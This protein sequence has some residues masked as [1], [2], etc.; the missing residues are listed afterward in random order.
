MYFVK[1]VVFKRKKKKQHQQNKTKQTPVSTNHLSFL[2]F[3]KINMLSLLLLLLISLLSVI[4]ALH[5]ACNTNISN[6]TSSLIFYDTFNNDLKDWDTCCEESNNRIE[7]LNDRNYCIDDNCVQICASSNQRI[8][9]YIVRN[10]TNNPIYQSYE[11]VLDIAT[12][13]G[14][15]IHSGSCA[16]QYSFNNINWIHLYWQNNDDADYISYNSIQA[17]FRNYV[18]SSNKLYIKLETSGNSV[19]H[20]CIYDRIYLYGI[21]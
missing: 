1:V 20:C 7:I 18:P 3:C 9:T 8:D 14:H 5:I 17:S 11:L 13:G 2:P 6:I 21:E 10:Q 15:N 16:I 19:N 4:N 12:H